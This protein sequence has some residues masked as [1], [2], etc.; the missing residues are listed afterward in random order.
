MNRTKLTVRGLHA[1]WRQIRAATPEIVRTH[2]FVL[3]TGFALILSARG[4]ETNFALLKSFGVAEDSAIRPASGVIEGSDGVLYG[5]T[6]Y[7]GASPASSFYTDAGAVFRINKDGGGFRILHHFSRT[8]GSFPGP[9][10]E[11]SDGN[12]YGSTRSGGLHERG[13]LF[14]LSKDGSNFVIII[15]FGLD[16]RGEPI[17]ALVEALDG[18]LFGMTL[19]SGPPFGSTLY[20]I[21]KDG[22]GYEAVHDFV[23]NRAVSGS[24]VRGA[25]GELYGTAVA[26]EADG[27]GIYRTDADGSGF[28]WLYRAPAGS[29]FY[30]RI[31]V[32]ASDGWLY[33]IGGS[34]TNTGGIF[35]LRKDGADLT[36][37]KMF[38]GVDGREPVG[39][40]KGTDGYLY[41]CTF[42][43][44]MDPSTSFPIPGTIFRLA[45]DGSEFSTLHEFGPEGNGYWPM[46]G[47][48]QATNGLLYGTTIAGAAPSFGSG[49]GVVYKIA[50]NGS[51]FSVLHR[52]D[53]TGG[54][55]ETPQWIAAGSNRLYGVTL[56]G[57]NSNTYG[58]IFTMN[59]DGTD[60]THLFGFTNTA[61]QGTAPRVIVRSPGEDLYGITSNGGYALIF[62]IATN[63]GAFEV[64]HKFDGDNDG[65]DAKNLIFGR[66]QRLYGVNSLNGPVGGGTVYSLR[67]NGTDFTVLRAMG[68]NGTQPQALIEGADDYLYG[69]AADGIFKLSKDGLFY[70]FLRTGKFVGALTQSRDGYLYATSDDTI[71]RV[72]PGDLRSDVVYR[73][74]EVGW[75][76]ALIEGTDGMLYGTTR[77]GGQLNSGVLFRLGRDGS[78][79]SIVQAFNR[80]NFGARAP[81][82][83]TE[84]GDAA[85]YV[86][87]ELGGR[88][89]FGTVCRVVPPPEIV[90]VSRS[91]NSTRIVIGALTGRRLRLESSATLL[92]WT[93]VGAAISVDGRANIEHA[94]SA[95]SRFYRVVAE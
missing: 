40:A 54:D 25:D 61:T 14:R 88:M 95:Q 47:V 76:N 35:S 7:G 70:Q 12:L 62:R 32:A 39:L 92:D 44:R 38:D 9:L 26:D 59:C 63:G 45:P 56:T 90:E 17:N 67:T 78:R 80:T 75:P 60:Y 83:L 34:Q 46:S 21:R 84:G 58:S 27:G 18:A 37:L 13:T 73:L 74:V 55:G 10:L 49:N 64:L 66:D 41:G 36:F 57:G 68:T 52:F 31:F 22:S 42:S 72:R 86:P 77:I 19:Y 24:L 28:T 3:A 94:G 43:G 48:V 91:S 20:R 89:D 11:A 85:L 5:T 93:V 8:D 30:P 65:W 15:H 16:S 69:A 2:F 50:T 81:A 23:S 33:G 87:T 53:R 71:L 79:F 6:V 82:M 1:R 29:S 4:A 51:D